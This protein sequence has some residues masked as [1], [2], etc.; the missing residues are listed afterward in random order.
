MTI[1]QRIRYYRQ[2]RGMTQQQLALETGLHYVS[3]RRYEADMREPMPEQIRRLADALYVSY[4][5]LAGLDIGRFDASNEDDI[6]SLLLLLAESGILD[7]HDQRS[8]TL[9]ACITDA[10]DVRI[11]GTDQTIPLGD[12]EL[13]PKS[14]DTAQS[15]T[16]WHS[17]RTAYKQA[18][19]DAGDH[20]NEAT[21]E[22]RQQMKEE[23][24]ALELKLQGSDS[25][26]PLS[27]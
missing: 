21:Q 26:H 12:I 8:F 5:A 20:P 23:L 14:A 6:V 9:N 4:F 25:A 11:S 7:V 24:E 19:Q 1:G 15:I 18:V 3:I 2:L 13:I 10:F 16:T 22:T 27:T 17:K